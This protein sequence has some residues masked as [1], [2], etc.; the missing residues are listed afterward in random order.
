MI[1]RSEMTIWHQ[2]ID[3]WERFAPFLFTQ[4]HWESAV[5]DVNHLLE[6]LDVQDGDAILDLCCGPGRHSLEFAR[7]GFKVTGVDVTSSY[8][9]EARSRA[10]EEDLS[11]EFIQEDAR[12]FRRSEAFQGVI[13][14]YT[15]FGYFEDQKENLRVLANVRESLKVGGK[16]V[17]DVMGKE[18]LARI[19]QEKDWEERDGVIYLQERKISKDWSWIENRWLVIDGSDRYEVEV[20]HWI[21]SA[22]EIATL[23]REAGFQRVWIHGNLAGS[24]YDHAARRLVCVAQK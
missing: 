17:I 22:T 19:F 3:F 13:L 15:S 2:K 14:M 12:Q 7:R 24:P 18:V 6:L 1:K 8:L 20:S 4:K 23:L 11:V 16:L 10:E 9:R 21:Y 5:D